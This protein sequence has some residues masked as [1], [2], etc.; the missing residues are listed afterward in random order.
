MKVFSFVKKVFIL[1]ST[2]LSSTITGTLKC[3][4]MN[5]QKCKVRPIL[6]SKFMSFPLILYII[7]KKSKNFF[8]IILV[9]IESLCFY[10]ETKKY[11]DNLKMQNKV[12]K[13][14]TFLPF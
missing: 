14:K 5:N 13:N 8:I 3:V 4:S 1:G 11:S 9:Y 12:S 10:H 6:S 7:Q 2:V